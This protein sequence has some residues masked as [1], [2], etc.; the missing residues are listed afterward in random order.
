MLTASHGPEAGMTKLSGVITQLGA[1]S[2]LRHASAHGVGGLGLLDARRGTEVYGSGS[3]S[4]SGGGSG[5]GSRLGSAG[6]GQGRGR[7]RVEI[8]LTHPQNCHGIH[9]RCEAWSRRS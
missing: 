6:R 2:G 3:G 7:M 8:E 5:S 4:G 9:R 1:H